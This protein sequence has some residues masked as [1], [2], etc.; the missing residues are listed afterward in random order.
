MHDLDWRVCILYGRDPCTFERTGIYAHLTHDF[1]P[2][3][4]RILKYCASYKEARESCKQILAEH[5]RMCYAKNGQKPP[6]K[7]ACRM[8]ALNKHDF[9]FYA[10]SYM[11]FASR[12]ALKG[13]LPRVVKPGEAKHII[14]RLGGDPYDFEI[15][16]K[17]TRINGAHRSYGRW[18]GCYRLAIDYAAGEQQGALV[19]MVLCV[20]GSWQGWSLPEASQPDLNRLISPN[21]WHVMRQRAPRTIAHDPYA[22]YALIHSGRAGKPLYAPGK[23]RQATDI[24]TQAALFRDAHEAHD[25]A[26]SA[27]LSRYEVVSR[28]GYGFI[29]KVNNYLS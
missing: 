5:I 20:L 29:Q 6:Q 1:A 3:G 23:P 7:Y 28:E 11:G 13:D 24:W 16:K 9:A 2:F 26:Y 10:E 15:G 14:K 4:C 12:G 25:A 22:G 21:N 19:N 27:G 17:I 18:G 8:E